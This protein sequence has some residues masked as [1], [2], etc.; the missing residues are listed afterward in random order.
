MCRFRRAISDDMNVKLKLTTILQ[1]GM[2]LETHLQH[3][4]DFVLTRLKV[5][6]LVRLNQIESYKAQ[7]R[8]RQES[9]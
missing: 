3:G 6:D 4:G 9:V 5:T 1:A 2:R 8:G 7:L